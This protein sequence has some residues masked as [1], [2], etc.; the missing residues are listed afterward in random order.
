MTSEP[1]AGQH[2]FDQQRREI[3]AA[4]ANGPL[5]RVFDEV[6]AL[7]R[8]SIRLLPVPLLLG[9]SGSSSFLGGRPLLPEELTWPRSKDR[10]LD[11]L[12]Q[13]ALTDVA[14]LDIEHALPRHG[15]FYFFYAVD[16]EAW[17]YR[18]GDHGAWKVLYSEA[19]HDAIREKA[20]PG[21]YEFPRSNVALALESM[22]PPAESSLV[23]SLQLS[24]DELEAY[25]DLLVEETPAG[26]AEK[27]SVHRLLGHPDQ[28]QGDMQLVCQLVSH[29]L[30]VGNEEGFADP[31]A[32]VLADSATSWR[33]LLQ[34]DSDQT[35][36]MQWGDWGRVFFWVREG[37]LEL[38]R[39]DAA[40]LVLQSH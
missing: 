8:P 40:W 15:V 9:S 24:E 1:H 34:L 22:L 32:Q 33:L 26:T 38:R 7:I 37:D 39:F 27:E 31:R 28:I 20:P 10:P 12:G 11:F 35:T 18:P 30:D 21:T 29:G 4:I 36:A 14:A 3:Q 13:I 6:S 25:W 19:T 17:G 16:G 2:S 23:S 5:I